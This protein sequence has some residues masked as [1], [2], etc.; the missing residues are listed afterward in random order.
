M[1]PCQWLCPR[2]IANQLYLS[3][4][5]ITKW[6]LFLTHRNNW[7]KNIFDRC[8]EYYFKLKL[9][10]MYK[11]LSA[12]GNWATLCNCKLV[13]WLEKKDDYWKPFFPPRKLAVLLFLSIHKGHSV[14]HTEVSPL[15]LR[16]LITQQEVQFQQ[17]KSEWCWSFPGEGHPVKTPR[18]RTVIFT[19]VGAFSSEINGAS[20]A[21]M[22]LNC[23]F[24]R[25]RC[26][27]KA[28]LKHWNESWR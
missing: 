19:A 24:P 10:E 3:Q 2:V 27:F 14:N 5:I 9:T 1:C 15:V 23:V 7:E 20:W 28:L 11:I 21:K 22:F 25:V 16:L 6:I 17:G 8:D 18:L 4:I 12:A 13:A 26:K